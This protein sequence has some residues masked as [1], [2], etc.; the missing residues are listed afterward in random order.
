ME[1][2]AFRT[3]VCLTMRVQR[4]CGLHTQHCLDIGKRVRLSVHAQ[5]IVQPGVACGVLVCSQGLGRTGRR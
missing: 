4:T 1:V 5:G 2:L 3:T